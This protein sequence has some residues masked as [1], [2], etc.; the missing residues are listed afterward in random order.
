[1]PKNLNPDEPHM[2]PEQVRELFFEVQESMAKDVHPSVTEIYAPSQI[3]PEILENGTGS[4]IDVDGTRLLFSNEHVITMSGLKHSFFGFDRFV[5]GAV[6]RYGMGQP[7]D[8]GASRVNEEIWEKYANGARAI[9]LSRIAEKHETVPFEILWMAGYP[10][11]RVRNFSDLTLAVCQALPTQEYLFLNDE[12]PHEKFDSDYHFAVAYSPAEAQPFDVSSSSKSP[13]LSDPHG[14]S[15]SLVWNTRRL[16]CY[17]AGIPWTPEIAVVTG[18]VWGWPRSN[19]L[20]ATKVEHF[21][22]FLRAVAT[23]ETP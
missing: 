22:D 6:Q 11:A 5:G 1:M 19:Y 2:P 16:E 3:N 17:Y 13:G 20:I 4:F 8:V 7:R 12:E 23:C 18:I 9:P 14:L 15:G 10:G 21:R